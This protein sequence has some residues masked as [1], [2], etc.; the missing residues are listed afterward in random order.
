MRYLIPMLNLLLLLAVSARAEEPNQPPLKPLNVRALTMDA[1]SGDTKAMEKLRLGEVPAVRAIEA[2]LRQ[3]YALSKTDLEQAL[4]DLKSEDARTKQQALTKLALAPPSFHA[5]LGQ[6]VTKEPDGA[7]KELM[8]KA[9]ERSRAAVAAEKDLLQLLT[10]LYVQHIDLMFEATWGRLKEDPMHQEALYL[11]TLL[12]FEVAWAELEHEPREEKLR[13]LLMR[14]YAGGGLYSRKALADYSAREIHD[15]ALQTYWPVM[16]EPLQMDGYFSFFTLASRVEDRQAY[17]ILRVAVNVRPDKPWETAPWIE[18]RTWFRWT[19][20]FEIRPAQLR[21][22]AAVYAEPFPQMIDHLYWPDDNAVAFWSARSHEK[23]SQN[24]VQLVRGF[25]LDALLPI[26][27]VGSEEVA[28]WQEGRVYNWARDVVP[29]EIRDEIKFLPNVFDPP[30][31][32]PTD[33]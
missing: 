13:F 9:L 29:A 25:P 10:E 14:M 2:A 15:M 23:L 21:R 20:L 28:L 17:R 18:V 16:L 32:L 6:R 31:K 30:P 7:R 11:L 1:L 4:R 8:R 24:A 19:Y 26:Y 12:P 5:W 33:W 27:A 3:R 22:D